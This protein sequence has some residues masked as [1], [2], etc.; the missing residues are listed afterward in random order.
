MCEAFLVIV[1]CYYIHVHVVTLYT[2]MCIHKHPSSLSLT[3]LSSHLF[4]LLSLSL[5]HFYTVHI[6]HETCVIFFCS[7][8]PYQCNA[9]SFNV[10]SHHNVV[11]KFLVITADV[12]K[13]TS[14]VSDVN[15]I[16]LIPDVGKL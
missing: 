9:I 7:F 11:R 8:T 14:D 1:V 5:A 16:C 6:E 2:Y 15:Q 4:S 10:A 12:N 3:P 13:A